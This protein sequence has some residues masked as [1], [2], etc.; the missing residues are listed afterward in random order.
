MKNNIFYQLFVRSSFFYLI[1]VILG[2]IWEDMEKIIMETSYWN[3]GP[4]AL[5]TVEIR[6]VFDS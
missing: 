6:W 2:K 4:V 1:A 5:T 3:F